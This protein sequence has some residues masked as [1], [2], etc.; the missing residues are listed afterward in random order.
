MDAHVFVDGNKRTGL[1]MCEL[2]LRMNGYSIEFPHKEIVMEYASEVAARQFPL[3]P[4]TLWVDSLVAE[5]IGQLFT[6]H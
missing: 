1:A 2:V 4:F 5:R 3:A 6:V